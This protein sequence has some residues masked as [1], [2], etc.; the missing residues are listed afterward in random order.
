M[1]ARPG[2]VAELRTFYFRTMSHSALVLKVTV[3]HSIPPHPF[4][5]SLLWQSILIIG[6]LR[7]LE[8]EVQSVFVH[9]FR[10]GFF[11][12]C[13]DWGEHFTNYSQPA[14]FLF[15]FYVQISSRAFSFALS[16][17]ISPQ[18][19]REL[20]RLWTSVPWRVVC[21]LVSL[22]GSYIMPG[23]HNQTTPTSFARAVRLLNI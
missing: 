19:F 16:A 10:D 17:R 1:K 7:F 9:H 21:E 4:H 3:M 22:I 8:S 13:G 11:L 6:F 5:P 18:C 12:A 23:Q 2:W 15:Y 14:C 20:R